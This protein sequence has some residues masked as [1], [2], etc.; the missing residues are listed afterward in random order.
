MFLC[1]VV[2]LSVGGGLGLL[3]VCGLTKALNIKNY[4]VSRK[5]HV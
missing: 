5:F 1:V 2:D 3:G 4:R